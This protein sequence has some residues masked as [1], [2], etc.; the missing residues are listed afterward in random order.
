MG[1]PKTAVPESLLTLQ[2][3]R[4]RVRPLSLADQV[5]R[6]AVQESPG[7]VQTLGQVVLVALAVARQ[8]QIL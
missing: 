7:I 5:L 3:H 6:E 4:E 1:L 2:L 8:E